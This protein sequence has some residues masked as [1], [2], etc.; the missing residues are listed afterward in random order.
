MRSIRG[1]RR[2]LTA[3]RLPFL[4]LLADAAL[5]ALVA[6]PA[7]VLLLYLL[8]PGVPLTLGGFVATLAALLPQVVA[9]F[10][11][12][13]PLL[14]LLAT[15]LSVGRSTRRGI[16]TRYVLRFALLDAALLALATAYQWRSAAELLADPARTA[17]ALTQSALVAATVVL[18]ALVVA[19]LRWP[20][21][22]GAPWILAVTLG[23]VVALGIATE[24]RRVRL[25]APRPI[26]MPGF[27]ASR[28]LLLLEIPGLGAD[29]LA[30]YS[31]IGAIP[32]LAGLR[33]RGALFTIDGGPATDALALHATLIT[34]REPAAH[35][36]I[37]SRRYRPVGSSRSFAIFPEGLFLRALLPTPLWSGEAVDHT[38]LRVAALPDIARALGVPAAIV[39]DP[40][41]WRATTGRLLVVR[42]DALA[43]GAAIGVGADAPPVACPAI[44]ETL[45][46]RFFDPPAAE[47]AGTPALEARVRRSLEEDLCALAVA[48]EVVAGARFPLLHVRLGGHLR[49]ARQFAGWREVT[50]AR[51]ASQGEIDAYG[52]TMA[53][54]VREL[55]PALGALLEAAG[56]RS[57]VAVVSPAGMRERQDLGRLAEA[58]AGASG[59]TADLDGPPP[60]LLLLAG[61][62][63]ARRRAASGELPLT[64]VLP[65]L[66]WGVDL[67]AAEDMGPLAQRAFTREYLASHPLVTVAGYTAPAA[68]RGGPAS[69]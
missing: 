4:W 10:V 63:V 19:D 23:T 45:A 56:K 3:G 64:S 54:Y 1:M 31:E 58:L 65:T 25:P 33:E 26:E 21:R 18:A 20:G 61:E 44:A 67:P 50:P 39:G 62:G 30:R 8:S 42:R 5:V 47:L 38:A 40:L 43:G 22:V 28:D 29:E 11:L 57:L 55:D 14:V 2:R 9:V 66:L 59:R 48:R 68:P 17:L 12:A 52:R 51:G 16:T 15:A 32:G 49:V 34:G 27:A 7:E 35:G 37:G 46:E 6:G 13:G 60:G 53:R 41:G 36:L 69:D 24:I